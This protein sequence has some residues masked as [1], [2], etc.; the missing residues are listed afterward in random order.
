MVLSP[1]EAHLHVA[2]LGLRIAVCSIVSGGQGEKIPVNCFV[3][4]FKSIYKYC[5]MDS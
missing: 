2:S 1:A 3:N 4:L 5:L